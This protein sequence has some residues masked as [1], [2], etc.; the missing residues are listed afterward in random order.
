MRPLGSGAECTPIIS[1]LLT[2]GANVNAASTDGRTALFA[3]TMAGNVDTVTLLLRNGA[4]V[5]STM[6]DGRR[7]LDLAALT[8]HA[9]VIQQLVR[10]GASVNALTQGV[11]GGATA[12][13]MAVSRGHFEAVKALLELGAD[14]TQPNMGW[15][16]LQLAQQMT[17][18]AKMAALLKGAIM[19]KTAGAK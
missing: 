10:A 9:D 4:Q 15:T 14:P 6:R 5:N 1:A 11:R 18:D 16:P 12:L 2:A 3:A 19:M 17:R 13:F 8:G 7:C